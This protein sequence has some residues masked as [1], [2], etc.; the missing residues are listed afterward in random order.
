MNFKF[1]LNRVS[2]SPEKI[3]PL[4]LISLHFFKISYWFHKID[5][6]TGLPIINVD[7]IQYYA[8]A[9]RAQEFISRSGRF[10]GY[11]PFQS[12]GNVSGLYNEV[13]NYL[14]NYICHWLLPLLPITRT[15]LFIELISL[16]LISFTI[17]AVVKNFGGSSNVSW[18]AFGFVL[19]GWGVL[20]PL[21]AYVIH[22]GIIW[23]QLAMFFSIWHVSLF[24][25]WVQTREL[26]ILVWFTV[27]TSLMF[28]L[29][30]VSLIIVSLPDILI[31]SLSLKSLRGR[32][33]LLMVFALAF[34]LA[35]NL[36]WMK[37]YFAFSYWHRTAPY[38]YSKGLRY[39]QLLNPIRSNYF[40][41]MR[42]VFHIIVLIFSFFSLRQTRCFDSKLKVVLLTWLFWLGM[43]TIYGSKIF[44][45][46][47]LQPARYEFPFWLLLYVVCA[48]SFQS[49]LKRW[50]QEKGNQ[51]LLFGT[52]LF[53][54]VTLVP[55]SGRYI[56]MSPLT[57]K[58]PDHQEK[59]IKYLSSAGKQ[60]ARLLIECREIREPHFVDFIP[61]VT[62]QNVVGG[63]HPGNHMITRYS[64]FSGHY[65]D[66][67]YS[68][69][70]DDP[71]AFNRKM[72][73]MTEQDFA[74][75]LE[76]YNVGT[77]AAISPCITGILNTW[78]QILTPFEEVGGYRFYRVNRLPSWFFSG[79]GTVSWDYDRIQIEKPSKGKIILKYHWIKTLRA[80]PEIPVEPIYLLD[81][82][83]P[84]ISI[85]NK[86]DAN[87][88][89]I[90][91]A[92][93]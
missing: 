86:T 74:S 53:F 25:K 11:D 72:K 76:L 27:V 29:H 48:F 12:A 19:L 26:R 36:Y 92:G 57:T 2:I 40:E 6:S 67:G 13:G 77:V 55:R 61:V 33:Y 59:V 3:G 78:T 84:F 24:W 69:I 10:W 87:E 44:W 8:R 70:T 15:L 75:R 31:L 89:V 34:V 71:I 51:I 85:D 1:K 47:T 50:A 45:I 56:R 60:E 35:T 38:Q 23:F 14:T 9:I 91:N 64:L 39:L 5:F 4:F 30:P 54:V 17:L 21:T 16:A 73:E 65:I 37:P 18:T 41:S 83:V 43:I 80:K 7:F 20:E 62:S 42:S 68:T 93:L 32:H 22:G 28:Q 82:P 46:K 52:L 90:Y 63:P 49:F 66:K 79:S 81:D 88:I 58:L